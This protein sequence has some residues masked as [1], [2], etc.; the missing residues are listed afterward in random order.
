MTDD[1]YDVADAEK[2]VCVQ[3]LPLA[4]VGEIRCQN[5]V[6]GALP[7]LIFAG[8]AGL[9][10]GT[11]ASR[12][13]DIGNIICV[14]VCDLLVDFVGRFNS[15]TVVLI[16]LHVVIMGMHGLIIRWLREVFV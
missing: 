16:N 4:I 10:G 9:G 2:A 11:V 6:G 7:T 12:V 1:L 15:C 13:V 5:A 14:I 3:E 8:G